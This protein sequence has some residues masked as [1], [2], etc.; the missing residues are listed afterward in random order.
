MRFTAHA[1]ERVGRGELIGYSGGG[2]GM[3]GAG[4]S[5]GCHLH[6]NLYVDGS[7]VDPMDSL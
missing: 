4:Y 3:Y 2:E 7:P 5:T 6:F 1:G